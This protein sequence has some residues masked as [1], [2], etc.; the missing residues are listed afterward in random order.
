MHI[1]SHRGELG[2]SHSWNK[3]LVEVAEDDLCVV[4]R[5]CKDG[6]RHTGTGQ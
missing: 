6:S 3:E 4:A 5:L 2:W 1:P